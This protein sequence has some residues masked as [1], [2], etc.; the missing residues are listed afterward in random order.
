MNN[1]E[2]LYNILM[3]EDPVKS[4]KSNLN[5]LLKLIPELKFEIGFEHRHPHHYLDV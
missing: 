5:E 1:Y 2:F 3:T 4:I